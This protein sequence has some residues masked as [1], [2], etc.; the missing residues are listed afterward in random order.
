M[1]NTNIVKTKINV[2]EI[3]HIIW[4]QSKSHKEGLTLPTLGS[5]TESTN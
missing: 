3:Y 5:K 1:N 4:F 2:V